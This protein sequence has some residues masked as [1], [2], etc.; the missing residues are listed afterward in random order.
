MIG[1]GI[2]LF[3]PYVSL[4]ERLEF[5]KYAEANGGE[6]NPEIKAEF[7]EKHL[8]KSKCYEFDYELMKEILEFYDA[9]CGGM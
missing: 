5:G 6:Y 4:Y 2:K 3:M 7:M 8:D 9:Y 1:S